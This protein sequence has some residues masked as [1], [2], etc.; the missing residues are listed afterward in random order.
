MF[1]PV[2]KCSGVYLVLNL[3]N[4]HAYVG[5]SV[6]VLKRVWAHLSSK[7]GSEVV[8]KAIAKYGRK[9]FAAYL[10]EESD[11]SILPF[12]EAYWMRVVRPEYNATTLTITGGRVVS[13]ETRDKLRVAQTGKKMKPESRAAI[14]ASLLGR[15]VSAETKEKIRMRLLGRKHK[16]ESIEKMRSVKW[17]DQRRK[18]MSEATIGRIVT[19]EARAI[20]SAALKGKPWS[21][22]RRRAASAKDGFI[23]KHYQL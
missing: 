6:N 15:N 22:A 16:I 7:K 20:R 2:R 14:R 23:Q 1:E 17:T 8:A 5:S 19:Q 13:K 3:V 10:L 12:R 4:G 18:N 21:E 11:R 9:N